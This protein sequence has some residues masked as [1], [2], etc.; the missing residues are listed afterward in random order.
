MA[1]MSKA[2]LERRKKK[3]MALALAGLVLAV[4][5]CALM[6]AVPGFSAGLYRVLGITRG[7][8]V[9]STG[10][11]SPSA[12][13]VVDV[14]QGSAVLLE[15]SGEFALID[16]GPPE[17]EAALLAYLEA[18]GVEGL[19]YVFL[20]HPHSDHYGAMVAALEAFPAQQVIL[21]DFSLAPYPTAPGFLEL[22]EALEE[23]GTPA[24]TAA[25]GDAYPLGGGAVRVL[26]AGLPSEDNY[27]LLSV[28][29]V[30]SVGDFAFLTTGD[31]E[32]A[33]ERAMLESGLPL[34]ADVFL[35]AHHG[36]ST[37]NSAAFLEAVRPGLAVIS[38]G[39]GNSYGHP[40]K[41]ALQACEGVGAALLRCDRHGN[42]LAQPGPDDGVVYAVSRGAPLDEEGG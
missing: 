41:S 2:R 6:L 8:V 5:L 33:N 23:S 36:S 16:A 12:V 25:V 1:R 22:I 37:S 28:A 3:R 7:A 40:H 24:A 42:I 30:F 14:G 35:T 32:K 34:G 19:R 27:N 15:E 20:T 21:P 39:A 29:L 26:H 11:Q 10:Q 13:H 4:L 31:G 38:C 9:P 18:A 17:G